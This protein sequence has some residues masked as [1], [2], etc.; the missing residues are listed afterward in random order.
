MWLTKVWRPKYYLRTLF[1]VTTAVCGSLIALK[2]MVANRAQARHVYGAVCFIT[3]DYEKL[4]IW[5]KEHSTAS[6]ELDNNYQAFDVPYLEFAKC[7]ANLP[8]FHVTSVYREVALLH[9]KAV[10]GDKLSICPNWATL[11]PT[12][13]ETQGNPF[14]SLAGNCQCLRLL[15]TL[16]IC[17]LPAHRKF[18]ITASLADAWMVFPCDESSKDFET[19]INLVECRSVLDGRAVLYV[20]MLKDNVAIVWMLHRRPASPRTPGVTVSVDPFDL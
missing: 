8:K 16:S 19:K 13:S 11:L 12:T 4:A 7:A 18:E 17:V 9:S 5:L 6:L 14:S 3:A 20:R 15:S 2:A 1:V 10:F